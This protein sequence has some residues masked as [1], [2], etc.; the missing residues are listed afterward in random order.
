MMRITLTRTESFDPI[1]VMEEAAAQASAERIVR[2][3]ADPENP[4]ALSY[5]FEKDSNSEGD[6]IDLV[7]EGD[8]QM[9]LGAVLTRLRE[10]G[11]NLQVEQTPNE[12]LRGTSGNR[13]END[14]PQPYAN[15]VENLLMDSG[16]MV[17]ED[18]RPDFAAEADSVPEDGAFSLV[19]TVRSPTTTGAA[20][21]A[22][23]AAQ[24]TRWPRISS[25]SP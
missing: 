25:P 16:W 8:D 7:I 15:E 1:Q 22:A 11:Y 13:R 2:E 9:A 17:R 20:A 19:M 24:T 10:R 3:H 23:G 14:K 18:S 12:E 5:R 21:T 4:E 6:Y